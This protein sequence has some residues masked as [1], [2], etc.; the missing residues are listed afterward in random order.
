[1]NAATNNSRVQGQATPL[2]IAVLVLL[3]LVSIGALVL[4]NG[5]SNDP[6]RSTP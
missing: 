6:E 5:D 1:M 4:R 3:A 2:I